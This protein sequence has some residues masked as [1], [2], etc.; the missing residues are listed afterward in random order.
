MKLNSPQK[1]IIIPS[2]ILIIFFLNITIY[3][4]FGY[5]EKIYF[6]TFI[7]SSAFI[8]G[9]L[10]HFYTKN[11][12]Y[13]KKLLIW[14]IT[15]IIII[16]ATI[17]ITK[18][19]YVHIEEAHWNPPEP[20]NPDSTSYL[21]YR[22]M[23]PDKTPSEKIARNEHEKWEKTKQLVSETREIRFRSSIF[24]SKNSTYWLIMTIILAVWGFLIF[25][26]NNEK[27]LES[28][29]SKCKLKIMI[30][31]EKIV[32]VI[33]TKYFSIKNYLTITYT[34][35]LLLI[36]LFLIKRYIF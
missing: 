20:W 29:G 15:S 17:F 34:L 35:I 13:E 14:A 31:E 28:N 6:F 3:E 5:N 11:A 27:H 16:A 9:F 32:C 25:S 10:K 21:I 7:L 24:R 12:K 4:T 8:L 1:F 23:H 36:V 26:K 18:G 2:L 30:N 22:A 19:P 33:P